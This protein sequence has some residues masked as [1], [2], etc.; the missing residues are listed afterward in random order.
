MHPTSFGMGSVSLAQFG[1]LGSTLLFVGAVLSINGLSRLTGIDPR[2]QAIV[3]VFAGSV[4]I[5]NCFSGLIYGGLDPVAYGSNFYSCATGLLFAFTFLFVA[6]NNLM[7]INDGRALGWYQGFV[8]CNAT[9]CGI[10]S[11]VVDGDF[12]YAIIWWLWAF[13]WLT[14]WVELVAKRNLGKF[15]GVLGIFEGVVAAWIPG[16][17]M[18]CGVWR[19]CW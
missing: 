16:F 1:S 5:C 8:A 11:W 4:G 19:F 13:L 18:I 17:M 7:G 15:V 10:L 9:A 12:V 14:G 2:A 6:Y 3:N